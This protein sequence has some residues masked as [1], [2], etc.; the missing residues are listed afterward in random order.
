MPRSGITLLEVLISIF[1]LAVGLLSVASLIPVASFQVQR[2]H[3]D[4]TKA[5]IGQQAVRDARVHGFF[6][7]D[8]WCYVNGWPYVNSKTGVLFGGGQNGIGTGQ[9]I[10]RAQALTPCAIDPCMFN[11]FRAATPPVF[12]SNGNAN[13]PLVMPRLTCNANAYYAA[14]DQVCLSQ[15]DLVFDIN[16]S[17]PDALP[18]NGFNTAKTKRSFQGQFS[19]LATLVPVRGDA[20]SAAVP[21]SRNAMILS[22]VVFNQRPTGVVPGSPGSG[23]R[24]APAQLM[25][26]GAQTLGAGELQISDQNSSATYDQAKVDLAVTPGE[27]IMLG[28]MVT[29]YDFLQQNG[30]PT[31][32]PMFRWYRV[33]TVG[34]ILTPKGASNPP[35]SPQPGDNATNTYAR[36]LTISGPEW[37]ASPTYMPSASPQFWAFIYDGAVA[38]YERTVHLEGPSMWSN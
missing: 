26:A 7:P 32:R 10:T 3:V 25:P 29:N 23:E 15:D 6:R 14:A 17:D 4:D 28:A 11:K 34:P 1:V 20:L 27:W 35:G 30:A 38:V 37:N 2:A 24:A 33:V 19:W 31:S 9:P 18:L 8:Y 13:N 5:L 21:V 22:I 16:S 12:A 36:D